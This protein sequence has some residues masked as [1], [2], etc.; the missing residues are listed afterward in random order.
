MSIAFQVEAS[1]IEPKTTIILA[2]MEILVIIGLLNRAFVE[3]TFILR[4]VKPWWWTH[5]DMW[6]KKRTLG[7]LFFVLVLAS[8][9]WSLKQSNNH[10]DSGSNATK[11]Q[12]IPSKLK[13]QISIHKTSSLQDFSTINPR[14]VTTKL[15]ISTKT[16]NTEIQSNKFKLQ[17][18]LLEV[19][20]CS[21]TR[22]KFIFN[23]PTISWVDLGRVP[24]KI[25]VISSC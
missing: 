12:K 22:K 23:T 5:F 25:S 4:C 24:L 17:Q 10:N 2:Q 15:H 13:Q 20:N 21:D 19:S 11:V 14:H 8:V 18:K 7:I 3:W 16:S 9:Y 6:M 1:S